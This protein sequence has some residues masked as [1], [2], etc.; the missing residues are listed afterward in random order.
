MNNN[1][2]IDK[3]Q[4]ICGCMSYDAT[5]PN[6]SPK[7]MIVE[8]CQ[9]LGSRTVR[10][11]KEPLGHTMT[12]LYGRMRYLTKTEAF[13]WRL[14]GWPPRGFEVLDEAGEW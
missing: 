12:N 9:R 3:A 1:D 8:L 13:M 6:G 4:A 7:A 2:L 10:I 11:K 14:F 5:T